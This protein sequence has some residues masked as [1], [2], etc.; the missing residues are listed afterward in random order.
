MGEI[1]ESMLDGSCCEMCGEYLGE[2]VGYPQTCAGCGEF[3]PRES[4]QDKRAYNRENSNRLLRENGYQFEE[5][6]GA[7][8]LIVQTMRGI[9]D[10]WPGT[11]K[12]IFR[13]SRLE[14]R[15]VFNLMQHA[16]PL[17]R[18]DEEPQKVQW[19]PRITP[20]AVWS[21]EQAG[22][23]VVGEIKEVGGRK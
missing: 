16:A 8:H 19:E 23:V 3:E 14:G 15:G 6:N 21:Y 12:F 1:A 22:I 11:G 7:A 9:V 18:P 5:K 17:N 2:A 4:S 20:F 13:E 10:F